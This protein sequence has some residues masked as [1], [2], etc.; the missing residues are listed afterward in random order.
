MGV[1]DHSEYVGVVRLANDAQAP[2]S[3][4]CPIAKQ[5]IVKSPDD[6]QRVYLFLRRRA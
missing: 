6:I 2:R 5:L 3:A 4:S 1:T